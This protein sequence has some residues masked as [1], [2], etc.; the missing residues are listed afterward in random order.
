MARADLTAPFLAALDVLSSPGIRAAGPAEAVEAVITALRERGIDEVLAWDDPLLAQLG[1]AE[2]ARREGI[3]WLTARPDVAPAEVRQVAAR[4][5]AGVTSADWGVAET[6]TLALRYGPGRPRTASLLP[7]VHIA[8]LPVERLLPDTAA[9][10]RKLSGLAGDGSFPAALN[11]VTGPSRSA[12][13]EDM[14]VRKVHGPGE[15]IV[16]LVEMNG[17]P[18]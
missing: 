16:V 5:G 14:L 1:L 6:G 12:D 2:A 13:I 8:V 7:P 3:T 11:L 18:D 17:G 9:L 4:A 10:F 15:V